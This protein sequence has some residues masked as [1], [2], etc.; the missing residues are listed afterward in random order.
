MRL[1]TQDQDS[2]LV[3]ACL[4]GSEKAWKELYSKY[5]NLMRTVVRRHSSLS[6]SDV[7]DVTQSAFLS[8]V[9]A[10]PGYD[11]SHSLSTFVCLIT[12]RVL[13][14]EI[15]RLKAT[16]RLAETET[17]SYNDSATEKAAIVVSDFQD[18]DQ[19]I[20]A[21]ELELILRLAVE[22]LDD[23]CRELLKMRYFNELTYKEISEITGVQE[24][25]LNVRAKRCL[26]RLRSVYEDIETRGI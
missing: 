18:V 12:E 17:L 7:Q 15:R 20:E 21:K 24:N 14:D 22:K 1:G 16:K 19:Q 8:L 6:E 4:S 9:S 3:K 26:D 5:L 10:L 11:F 23:R 2:L 13:I 25:T